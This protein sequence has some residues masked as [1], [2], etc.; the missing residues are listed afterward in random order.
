MVLGFLGDKVGYINKWFQNKTANLNAETNL[1]LVIFSD[2]VNFIIDFGKKARGRTG[3][4]PHV[5]V[6]NSHLIA[7]MWKVLLLPTKRIFGN[8]AVTWGISFVV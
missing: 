6:E 2:L 8:V 1:N 5:T 4:S 7:A 3:V